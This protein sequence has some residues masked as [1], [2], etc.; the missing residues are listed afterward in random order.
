MPHSTV[1]KKPTLQV[2]SDGKPMSAPTLAGGNLP[3]QLALVGPKG[4]TGTSVGF[5]AF[6]TDTA[7]SYVRTPKSSLSAKLPLPSDFLTF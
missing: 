4:Q 5:T 1:S 3:P 6:L 2:Q 7:G